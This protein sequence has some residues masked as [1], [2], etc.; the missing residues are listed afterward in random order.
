MKKKKE[1]KFEVTWQDLQNIVY[2]FVGAILMF[3]VVVQYSLGYI[4]SRIPEMAILT[5]GFFVLIVRVNNTEKRLE[6]EK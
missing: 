3:F 2:Q 5:V 6:E 4:G 1:Y